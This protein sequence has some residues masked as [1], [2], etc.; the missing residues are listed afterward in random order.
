MADTGAAVFSSPCILGLPARVLTRC[1]DRRHIRLIRQA[2]SMCPPP[3]GAY[4]RMK[5]LHVVTDLA[6]PL[7]LAGKRYH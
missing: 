7:S 3:R 2:P 4:G 1:R 6:G 5:K